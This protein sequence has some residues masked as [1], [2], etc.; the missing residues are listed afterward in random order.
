MDKQFTLKSYEIGNPDKEHN[1]FPQEVVDSNKLLVWLE[2][3]LPGH[4]YQE[5]EDINV[6]V[7]APRH[8]GTRLV[9][10]VSDWPCH[11]YMCLPGE[12]GEWESGPYKIID[13]GIL[14]R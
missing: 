13:W 14:E 1:C 11:V 12:K 6:L 8:E 4:V 10:N 7:L 2:P 5:V 3:P 9:P